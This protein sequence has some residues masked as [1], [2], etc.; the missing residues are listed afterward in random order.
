MSNAGFDDD[1]S[2][3][4]LA[5]RLRSVLPVLFG[6]VIV[7]AC[8]AE[9][10][11]AP[12]LWDDQALLEM[13]AIA[14]LRPLGEYLS[15]PFWD[16]P[17]SSTNLFYRPI[18][19][20]SLALDHALHGRNAAGFHLTN[21]LLHLCCAGLVYALSRRAGASQL[22]GAIAATLWALVPRSTESVAWISG[23]TDQL[24]TLFALAAWLCYRRGDSWRVLA[25][26]VSAFCALLSKE[27]GIAALVAIVCAELLP[28]PTR[29]SVARLTPAAVLGVFYF[30]LRAR[31]LAGSE[32]LTIPL[33]PME[34][35]ATI[36]E[37]VGH[38]GW[39][40]VDWWHP[41]SQIGVVKVPDYRFVA[42]GALLLAAGL[43]GL[44]RLRAWRWL[45]SGEGASTEGVFAAVLGFVPLLLVIHI[46]P[47]PWLAVAGDRMLYLP[48]AV[49]AVVG[50]RRLNGLVPGRVVPAMALAALIVSFAVTTRAQAR[51]YT[52]SVEFWVSATE[53]TPKENWG[54]AL[55]LAAEFSRAGLFD[56]ALAILES[57]RAR[58]DPSGV[59]EVANT[60]HIAVLSSLG[61]YAEA[62]KSIEQSPIRTPE[63]QLAEARVHAS[64]G[65]L[66]DSLK[67]G[68]QVLKTYP[69][70]REAAMFVEH[71][72]RL[73]A[74]LSTA[75][76][77]AGPDYAVRKARLETRMGRRP[78]ASA[79]WLEVL[80]RED[81]PAD[82]VD[83]GMAFLIAY[84]SFEDMQR[85]A[86]LY[87]QRGGDSA[88]LA[89]NY[90]ERVVM[91]ERL[92]ALRPR[93]ERAL[94]I[95]LPR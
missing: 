33:A 28:R 32:T 51:V 65:K 91:V 25:A 88:V 81:A 86:P 47:M 42:F 34:R 3:V 82:V 26:S 5:G 94:G 40:L 1:A 52:D 64:Q 43:A 46:V 73:Q 89:L 59:Q 35:F 58:P 55:E 41:Q 17:D 39:M 16:R 71:Q 92:R 48:L 78:T 57:V 74:E 19:T 85:G 14:E 72:E 29:S 87:R 63:V 4:E 80:A 36:L 9:T 67:L 31:A 18:T 76:P 2:K 38:Y 84:G 24:C 15:T 90:E 61:R 70:F 60:T 13:P 77:P 62:L 50:A 79:A 11:G 93:I 10:L 30:I 69:H 7:L 95:T 22:S 83:E 56:Q 20:L 49:L 23:R 21:V 75:P 8:Y 54:P 45:R 37:A 68:R 27:A 6:A 44:V 66:Q 12:F 53:T